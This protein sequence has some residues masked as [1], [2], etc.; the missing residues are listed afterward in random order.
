MAL[1]VVGRGTRLVGTTTEKF[2]TGSLNMLGCRHNH[3]RTFDRTRPSHNYSWVLRPK[4]HRPRRRIYGNRGELTMAKLKA[5]ALKF[6]LNPQHLLNKRRKFLDTR[7]IKTS[8]LTH[9]TN[10]D[11]VLADDFF[12]CEAPTPKLV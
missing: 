10:H 7:F 2:C 3:L 11:L 1:K 12:R 9:Q 6:L 5:S 4:G 8:R